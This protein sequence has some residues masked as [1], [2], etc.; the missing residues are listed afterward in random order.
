MTV[1]MSEQ[2]EMELLG[3]DRN[4]LLSDVHEPL[5]EECSHADHERCNGNAFDGTWHDCACFC[6]CDPDWECAPR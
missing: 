6:H 5:S 2:M 4:G 3:G 1:Y